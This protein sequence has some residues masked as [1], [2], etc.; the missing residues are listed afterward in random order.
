MED[1]MTSRGILAAKYGA[2]FAGL[3]FL[4]LLSSR[5]AFAQGTEGSDLLG[6]VRDT[7]GAS[8]AGAKVIATH[9]ATNVSVDV[10]SDDS[11]NFAFRFLPPGRYNVR[12][13]MT[14]FNTVTV[15]DVVLQVNINATVAITVKPASITESVTVKA[16]TNRIETTDAT[17]KHSITNEQILG[18]PV[19]TSTAGRSVLNTLPFLAP[20]VVSNTVSGEGGSRG[21]QISINGSRPSSVS[22]NFE[23]GDNNDHENNRA[24]SPLPNPDA[25]GEFTIV[26]N[27]YKADLGRSSG[28]IINAVTKAGTNTFHGNL[29]YFLINEALNARSFFD[30]ERP[31]NR[32]NTFGGNI[33]GPVRLPWLY[34]GK[35]KTFFFV[36]Y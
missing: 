20:G 6:T 27:N 8:V 25:L 21:E 26:T 14:G 1:G 33:G 16:E 17:V 19:L 13:E 28:G 2:F 24:A 36:D 4:V 23:G 30:P 11:G 7:S 3:L 22:F 10:K 32:L 34:N 9:T 18:L 15:T 5:P 29:R 35:D 31:L 12:A